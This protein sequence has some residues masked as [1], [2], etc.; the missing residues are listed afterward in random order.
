M[1][2]P[3]KRV[4][5]KGSLFSFLLAIIL[6]GLTWCAL[7]VA[8]LEHTTCRFYAAPCLLN[9]YKELAGAL[10]GAAGTI[11]AGWLAWLGVQSQLV[12]QRR[13]NVV[14]ERSFLISERA[15]LDQEAAG[16]NAVREAI[17]PVAVWFSLVL[18]MLK[19]S[20]EAQWTNLRAIVDVHAKFREDGAPFAGRNDL[21]L[22]RAIAIGPGVYGVRIDYLLRQLDE[23]LPTA[24]K[25]SSGDM[26][27]LKTVNVEYRD[28]M[29][30]R[31]IKDVCDFADEVDNWI[32]TTNTKTNEV[33]D[34]LNKR[35]PFEF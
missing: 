4:F 15:R 28:K 14:A 16:Y 19:V 29:A 12:E 7:L 27:G 5:S 18:P 30:G 22:Q 13:A 11:F 20:P 21:L 2:A 32:K 34:A 25:V 3:V 8:N 33:T 31:A 1:D 10:L 6:V 26:Q 17:K 23:L 35:R 9:A 24:K